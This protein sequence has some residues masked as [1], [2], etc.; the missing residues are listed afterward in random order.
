MDKLHFDLIVNKQLKRQ[1]QILTLLS[2]QKAPMKLEQISN[3]LNTSARTTAEDLKQLQ[4]ILPENCMIKGINNVGY[5]LEW[6]ASVNINQVVSKIAEKSH[7]YVIIDGLF[8][9]K[10]QSVQDWA[11]KLFISEKTLVR[12]LKNFKQILKRF[13]L[14]LSSTPLQIV[15]NEVDIRLFFFHYYFYA[16]NSPF[17]VTPSL[18]DKDV[19]QDIFKAFKSSKIPV[20]LQEN[21]A[22]YWAMIILQRIQYGYNVKLA[23]KNP[24]V[25]K[26]QQ[27]VYY[28]KAK[29]IIKRILENHNY[30]DVTENEILFI[31]ISARDSTV[32]TDRLLEFK[33]TNIFEADEIEYLQNFF[34]TK[35]A[36]FPIK[37]GDIHE[38]IFYHIN[39]IESY[40]ALSHLSPG[41]QL[42]SYEMNEFIEKNH[43]FTFSKWIDI[44][45]KEPYFQKEIW[46]NLE[47][48][49]VN[50]TMLTSTFTEIGNNKTHIVFALSGNSFYLNYI[51]HIAHELIHPSVKISYLYDQ[52]ISEEWLKEKQVDILV[53]NFEIHPS[54]ANVVS[55]H[56]SQIPSSQEWSMISKM[57]MDLSR[58]EMHER[59]DPYSDNIFLN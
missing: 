35:L 55:L 26:M 10:I 18:K 53:H 9:D 44:L 46:E 6:D 32:Y 15:G 52:Q 22:A 3:E 41:F 13:N 37:K 25:Q 50:L 17:S 59:F 12:Y 30:Q 27:Q 40:Y 4:Y 38:I 2:N 47:D 8:N 33:T 48:I 39:F 34:K 54:F 58:A 14:K 11:E 28:V 56:V 21:R 5:S 24:V 1:I 43:P 19:I 23:K 57:V 16:S 7:L 20:M 29:E 31:L 36:I 49:A 51:K 45:Q 42:N